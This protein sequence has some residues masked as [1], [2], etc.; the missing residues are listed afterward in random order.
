MLSTAHPTSWRKLGTFLI[1]LTAVVVAGCAAGAASAP[2]ASGAGGGDY[3]APAP[4]AAPGR[5]LSGGDGEQGGDGTGSGNGGGVPNPAPEDLLIIKTGDMT[6]QVTGIDPALTAA[7]QQITALGGYVSASER[8]GDGDSAFARVTF[9]I[10]ADRW[11][12]ALA[13]LRGLGEKV[14]DEHTGTQDVTGQVVDLGARIKNL[15]ATEAAL[16]EIMAR[17]TA[18]KDVLAVQAEL[19]QVREQIERLTAEKGGLEEQAAYS[20]M[21]VGFQLKP[22]PVLTVQENYDPATEVD[23]ASASLV[24][25]LQ[26]LATAGIWFA[27]VWVPIIL[28]LVVIGLITLFVV[29][30]IQRTRGGGTAVTPAAGTGA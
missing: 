21:T 16:Q 5:N 1:L 19:T 6:L 25:I 11:D 8:S 12:E 23:A 27:I 14:L 26:A 2:G 13:G 28:A 22:T 7:N 17:A 20:T 9:R 3:G 29:R 4:T 15:Q 10:P 30:R 24:S 18:I